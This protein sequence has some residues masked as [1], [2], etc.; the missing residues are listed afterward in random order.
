MEKHISRTP[1]FQYLQPGQNSWDTFSKTP[2]IRTFPFHLVCSVDL[3]H[4]S[5][6]ESLQALSTLL[7]GGGG[8]AVTKAV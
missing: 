8:S 1:T 4:P 3:K 5:H 7:G 6:P 2:Q